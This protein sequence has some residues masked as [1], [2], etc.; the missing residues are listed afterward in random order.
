MPKKQV[1][2]RKTVKDKKEKRPSLPGRLFRFA[3]YAGSLALVWGI[4]IFLGVA[5]WFGHDLPQKTKDIELER[6]RSV[7]ILA[8]DGETV[9]ARYG[10]VAGNAVNVEDLPEYIG[11]AVIA[12]E[13]RRFY[14]HIGIDPIGILRAAKTN[15]EAGRVVQGGSTITQ[16]LAKNLFLTP[17]RTL[18]RKIQE[19]LLAL[20]LELTLSKDEILSAYLNRVYFGA[21]AYGLDAAASIYFG[22][23][24]QELSLYE[25][26]MMAGLL[27]A[28]S[29]F[30]P[31]RNLDM[32][33]ERAD[34]VMAAM[35]R[36]GYIDENNNI[37]RTRPDEPITPPRKPFQM[38][39]TV[40]GARYFSDWIVEGL[41]AFHTEKGD[42]L[43]V[44]T[45]LDPDIQKQSVAAMKAVFSRRFSKTPA[46]QGAFIILDDQGGIIAMNGGKSYGESQFNRATD[47]LRQP[48]S[49]MK[50]FVYL[51]ALQRGW[52]PQDLVNDSEITQGRYRPTNYDGEYH[53]DIPMWEALAHSYNVAAVRMLDT[54]GVKNLIDLMR[55]LGVREELPHELALALGSADMTM[56]DILTPYAVLQNDG[57]AVQ[58]FGMLQV[59]TNDGE[60]LFDRSK[61]IIRSRQILVSEY[62]R[63][64]L[65]LMLER[66]MSEGTGVKAYPGFP[67]A[68]KTGTTQKNRDAWFAGF[69]DKH[70]A[71]IWL[72]H[73][74]NTPMRGVYGGT[75][76][77]ELWRELIQIAH[78]G[79]GA[80]AL[81]N[82]TLEEVSQPTLESI[83]QR[84]FIP[85]RRSTGSSQDRHHNRDT[86]DDKNYDFNE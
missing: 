51:A 50:P 72:G 5:V 69:T 19:A 17:E 66:V 39:E 76:P 25:A 75:V 74:D 86:S 10:E 31:T 30:A 29:R 61:T 13:D 42:D 64:A 73:D 60:I 54:V 34:I 26:A 48:G 37:T 84:W 28:P 49:L 67:S 32:A 3:V 85:G 20:W 1:K 47:A 4:I 63:D 57:E 44:I 18:E 62:H 43:T 53:D 79:R 77:A 58:P 46:P 81:T 14:Y 40:P 78:A 70:T 45:T 33:R 41:S 35:R 7:T 59:R 38:V 9:L 23:H 16:Q 83:F 82:T 21:G 11:Q 8:R 15:M 56:M 12:I 2:R 27:K 68:G 6:K 24:A 36:S 80:T 52:Q 65:V 71:V 22:K 55:S